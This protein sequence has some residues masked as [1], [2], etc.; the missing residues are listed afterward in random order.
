M[1]NVSVIIAAYNVEL[2]ID[3]CLDSVVQQTLKDIEIIVVNDGSTDKTLEKLLIYANK[4]NRIKIVDK[5][6]EGLIEARKS[7]LEVS[8]GEFL[9]F[10]DADDWLDIRACEKLYKKAMELDLDILCYGLY[11][12]FDNRLE[13]KNIYDFKLARGE[14]YL[15]FVLLN[16][17]RA[18]IVLQ[19]LKREFL[20]RNNI[21][22][23]SNITY[24]EDL[25]ITV[26]LACNEPIVGTL[27]EPLYY[28]YQRE[29]SVT[30]KVSNKVFDVELA[31]NSIRKE[32]DQKGYM[33]KYYYEFEYLMFIH[34]YYHRVIAVGYTGEIHKALYDKWKEKKLNIKNNKYYKEFISTMTIREKLK[35]ILYNTNYNLGNIY[36]VIYRNLLRIIK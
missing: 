35:L 3:R 34:L 25:A 2:Y 33:E 28:Y 10:V 18:N 1:A 7:G 20:I 19:L 21:I 29:N 32:L 17:A 11:H 8:S 14:E 15:N 12:A 30:N 4:D 23:P 22:F 36:S 6:N 9:M 5:K 31:I 24:A 16:K 26:T 27:N 13:I